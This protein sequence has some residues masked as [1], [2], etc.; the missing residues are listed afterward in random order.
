MYFFFSIFFLSFCTVIL[1][2]HGL[3]GML[4]G[5][6]YQDNELISPAAKMFE[7]WAGYY[8]VKDNPGGPSAGSGGLGPGSLGDAGVGR[9]D[10]SG[11]GVSGG[12]FGSTL[13][14]GSGNSGGTNKVPNM[15]EVVVGGTRM[16]YPSCYVLVCE[17]DE[18][19]GGGS[20]LQP[21]HHQQHQQQHPVQHLLPSLQQH[22]SNLLQVGPGMGRTLGRSV[23]HLSPPPS[24]MDSTSLLMDTG[25]SQLPQSGLS[26]QPSQQQNLGLKA[27]GLPG[28][29]IGGGPLGASTT[30]IGSDSMPFISSSRAEV[31]GY[32]LA[33]K[34]RQDACLNT[35]SSKR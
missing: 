26:S 7:E 33:E 15:V 10:C 27:V 13:G 2:P 8:P 31:L 28:S 1:A 16:A 35:L 4:T 18:L 14:N 11:M 20:V 22:H 21:L 32:Q 30:A 9:D 29:V 3:S 6:T 19:P 24:P 34:V 23:S 12:F 5:V 17:G 25:Q